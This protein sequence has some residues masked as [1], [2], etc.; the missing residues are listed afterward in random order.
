VTRTPSIAGDKVTFIWQGA[1]PPLLLGDFNG[2]DPARAV[3]LH[4]AK[5]GLWSA[6]LVLPEDV[7]I[8][9]AFRRE[10][11]HLLDPG[12][13][14]RVFNGIDKHNNYFYMPQATPTPLARRRGSLPQ[15][16]LTEHNLP[17]SLGLA[18]RGV[19]VSLH[20][21]QVTLYQPAVEQPCPLLLVYD[22]REYLRYGHIL[23]IL[24]NLIHQGVIRPVALALMANGG[25]LRYVEY[26]CSD[27]TLEIV[28]GHLLPLARQHLNLVDIQA[29]P[30]A[31]GVMGASMGGLMAMYTAF[32]MPQVFGK[33]LSQSGAFFERILL[34]QPGV[35]FDRS[36]LPDLVRLQ[37]RLPLDIWMDVGRLELLLD[38]NRAFYRLLASRGYE[39][40]Y[41]E[42]SGGHNYTAWRDDLARGLVHLFGA[43]P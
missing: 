6:E 35:Y 27:A 23:T 21:R 40:A 41:H 1:N 36:V 38:A 25:P 7:Y 31:F 3:K 8:E 14:R 16:M 42:Y 30:G 43:P 28:F 13:P 12:N 19:A 15:G 39:P 26:D 10:D 20:H 22:G 5:K 4:K 18:Q 24:D 34:N 37:E 32:R 33:V 17:A 2:W 9:Y 29:Q 11:E